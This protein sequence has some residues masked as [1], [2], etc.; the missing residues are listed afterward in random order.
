MATSKAAPTAGLADLRQGIDAVDRELLALLN[1]RAALSLQVG[2]L[3]AENSGPVFRP[4][5]EH[6][7]LERLARE[8]P[9]PLPT[10]HIQSIWRE[11]FSSSRTLQ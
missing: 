8:N 1:R 9:G 6:E 2:Q 7:I 11:I 3:K 10:T 4:Q 5:R